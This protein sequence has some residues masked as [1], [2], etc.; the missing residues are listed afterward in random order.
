[1]SH[2]IAIDIGTTNVKC[3]LCGPGLRVVAQATEEYQTRNPRPSWAEQDPEDWWRG[4]VNTLRSVLSQS[5]IDPDEIKVISVSSQAPTVLPVDR[6]GKPL[7]PALIWMDR[8]S[9]S[10]IEILKETLG[11][12]RNY[13]INGNVLDSYFNVSELLWMVKHR[14]EVMDKCYRLLQVSTYIVMK[15]TGEFIIDGSHLSLCG[16]S[17]IRK[18][19]W[20]DEILQACGITRD[21]LPEIR[22]C[23]DPVGMVREEA[24]KETGLSKKTVVLAGTVDAT[25][26]AIEVGV[27]KDGKAAEMTGT[28]SVLMVGYEKLITSPHL[29]YF[30]GLYPGTSV[31]F[32]AMNS[33]GGSLKWFRDRLYGGDGPNHDAYERINREVETESTEPTGIIYL[34]YLNGERGPIWDPDA[35]GTFIGI[36]GMTSRA[37]LLRAIMEGTSFGLQHNLEQ[38]YKTGIGVDRLICCGGCA[39]SDIWL[40]IKASVIDREIVV[41]S[42]SHGATGGLAYMNAAFMGEYASPEEACD[43]NFSIQKTVEPDPA[44]VPVYRELYEVYKDSYLSLK[45]QYKRIAKIYQKHIGA[46][47][48]EEV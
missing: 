23:M 47:K 29:S 10:E 34:P 13:E 5:G 38:V 1:M 3:V 4:C 26:A 16:L 43:A 36:H 14:P 31:L 45:D 37:D 7:H 46:K 8:R 40:S 22:E 9:L 35:R 20:S 17:D 21:I 25:A 27:Y 44:L 2:S 19:D 33:V 15:L 30:E 28:S 48:G 18:R 12:E 6:D 11:E 41:P 42:V 24:A 39:K 32:G